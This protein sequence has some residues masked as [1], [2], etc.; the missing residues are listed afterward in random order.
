V[1]D[2]HSSQQPATVQVCAKPTKCLIG[3]HYM[4]LICN[5]L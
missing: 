5:F 3:W 4:K 1:P 2:Q